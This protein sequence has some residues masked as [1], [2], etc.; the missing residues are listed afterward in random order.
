[1]GCDA[2]GSCGG[3][4]PETILWKAGD[5]HGLFQHEAAPLFEIAERQRERIEKNGLS[6]IFYEIETPLEKVLFGHGAGGLSCGQACIGRK[7]AGAVWQ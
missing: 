4:E 6:K 7:A 5:R 3:S 1:M 2:G